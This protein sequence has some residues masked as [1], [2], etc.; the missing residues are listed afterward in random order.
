MPLARGVNVTIKDAAVAGG[1][2]TPV[3]LWSVGNKSGDPLSATS[4]GWGAGLGNFLSWGGFPQPNG[5]WA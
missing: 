2:A 5:T 3:N 4:T 1:V